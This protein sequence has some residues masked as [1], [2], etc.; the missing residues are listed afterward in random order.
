VLSLPLTIYQRL[1]S[2]DGS[3]KEGVGSDYGSEPS[4]FR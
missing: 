2:D 3:E 1:L 4:S